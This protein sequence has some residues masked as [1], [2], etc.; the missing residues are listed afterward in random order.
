MKLTSLSG[1]MEYVIIDLR[2]TFII[3]TARN[4]VVAMKRWRVGLSKSM[5]KILQSENA[6][7]LRDPQ[8]GSD[9]MSQAI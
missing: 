2:N 7:P 1:G 5:L 9:S 3:H 6:Q 4:V 8:R